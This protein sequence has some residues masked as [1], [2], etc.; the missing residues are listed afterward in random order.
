MLMK[1]WKLAA[2]LIVGVFPALA[3]AD[4]PATQPADTASPP[5]TPNDNPYRFRRFDGGYGRFGGPG[6]Y[7]DATPAELADVTAV[8][9]EHSPERL[10][11][12]SNLPDFPRRR[13]MIEALR[14]WRNYQRVKIDQPDLAQLMVTRVELEDQAF[15]LVN[16]I[17][18]E[19]SDDPKVAM[20]DR[21]SLQEKIGQLLDTN[22]KERQL[23]IARLQKTLESEQEQLAKDSKQRDE[24]VEKR[25]HAFLGIADIAPADQ[26]G[27]TKPTTQP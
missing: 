21:Q 24:L 7:R 10:K 2:I 11:A 9:K 8:M 18:A 23:R 12:I 13:L 5:T 20:A 4:D 3:R 22:I 25:L 26:S 14:N 17:K 1:F 19:K 15:K 16:Q 27:T 6:Y